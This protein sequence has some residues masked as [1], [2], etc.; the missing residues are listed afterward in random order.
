M[1]DALKPGPEGD[2]LQ[3]DPAGNA[4]L[5]RAMGWTELRADRAGSLWGIHP[6]DTEHSLVPEFRDTW[7]GLGA[8]VE[9]MQAKGWQVIVFHQHDGSG[10]CQVSDWNPVAG[11]GFCVGETADTAPLAVGE[12]L[13]AAVEKEKQHA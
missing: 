12:V 1:S 9:W 6:D 8:M 3:T 10:D 4:K 7:E 2:A 13:L 5:A 11:E